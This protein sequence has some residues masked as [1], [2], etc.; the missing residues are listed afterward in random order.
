MQHPRNPCQMARS[1]SYMQ[2]DEPT[3]YSIVGHVG[4]WI[5]KGIGTNM[6][7]AM[8]QS[9]ALRQLDRG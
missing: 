3:H 4:Q 9:T 8:T 7:D 6:R 2:D 5:I 1:I